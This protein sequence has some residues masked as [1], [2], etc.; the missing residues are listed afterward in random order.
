VTATS[1][2]RPRGARLPR[3]ARRRQL[4]GAAQEVF[5]SQGYHAA[6][7][8]EIADRAGIS[9]PVL[10]QHFPSKLEL[11]L[12]LLDESVDALIATVRKALSS[13]NDN[14]QRVVATFGAYFGF[15]ANQGR[16]AYSGRRRAPA[17]R[18]PGGDGSGQRAILAR[19]RRP[20][21]PGGSRAADGPAGLAG[22]Q[23]LAPQQ[24]IPIEGARW[25]YV[26]ESS[27]PRVS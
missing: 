26:S 23:R 8:D 3:Q 15:V 12:A 4:L 24:L 10:Y 16:H 1:D 13:T 17:Q 20:H 25:K 18:G 5:V 2:A 6:A 7:M 11:Y 27:P 9:K 14:K 21:S 22:D 19:Q